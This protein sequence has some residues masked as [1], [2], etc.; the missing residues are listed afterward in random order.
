MNTGHDRAPVGI[1]HAQRVRNIPYPVNPTSTLSVVS[2]HI[3]IQAAVKDRILYSKQPAF[4]SQYDV[5][6]N[7]LIMAEHPSV[8]L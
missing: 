7:P 2:L 4:C 3:D 5:L 1:L 6:K 8:A